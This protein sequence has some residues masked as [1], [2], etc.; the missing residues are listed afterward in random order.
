MQATHPLF[1]KHLNAT[2]HMVSPLAVW[3][4][5]S[6]APTNSNGYTVLAHTWH[7]LFCVISDALPNP[8]CLEEPCLDSD[9]SSVDFRRLI[10]TP[11]CCGVDGTGIVRDGWYG[12][13]RMVRDG[14][15]GMVRGWHGSVRFSAVRFGSV[16]ATTSQGPSQR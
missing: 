3:K 7:F 9:T 16:P 6:L 8:L 5:F 11:S 12:M 13:V 4:A 15:Y 1:N 14:W 2:A 10:L